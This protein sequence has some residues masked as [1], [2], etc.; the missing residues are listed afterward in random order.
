MPGW[1]SCVK[2]QLPTSYLFYTCQCYFL[3]S[4]PAS[5]PCCA[6]RS[7]LYFFISF[8]SLQIDPKIESVFVDSIDVCVNIRYLFL[9]FWLTSLCKILGSSTSLPLTQIYSSYGWII[10]HCIYVPPLLCPFICDG[11]LGCFHV[12]AI[13]NNASVN[14]GVHVSFWIV[15]FSGYTPSTGIA[16]SY[17]VLFLVF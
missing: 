5:F 10:L 4:S 16:G 12:L 11:Y 3:N 7:L 13:L 1:A 6:H 8:H 2:Q 15:V 14:I 17:V 9:S